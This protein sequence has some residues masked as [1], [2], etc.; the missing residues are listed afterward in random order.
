MLFQLKHGH[1]ED[2]PGDLS[3]SVF[4]PF[5]KCLHY[6]MQN[7]IS[8][9]KD[10]C[11]ICDTIAD[12]SKHASKCLSHPEICSSCK[13]FL[14]LLEYHLNNCYTCDMHLC[15]KLKLKM[16]KLGYGV[17]DGLLELWSKI[18][19]YVSR[20]LPAAVVLTQGF[21]PYKNGVVIPNSCRT[22]GM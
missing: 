7:G 14:H 16:M 13:S 15:T 6:C 4:I 19:Q 2:L 10:H 11:E 5:N 12:L 8:L 3:N 21:V 20:F 17:S 1:D 22:S 9:N 18:Q